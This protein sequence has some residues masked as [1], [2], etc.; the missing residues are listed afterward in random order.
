[1][2]IIR[3]GEL[4][5][6]R[7]LPDPA[8]PD[9]PSGISPEEAGT[10]PVS[11]QRATLKPPDQVEERQFALAAHHEIDLRNVGEEGTAEISRAVRSP[12]DDTAVGMEGA[13]LP[14]QV[15]GGG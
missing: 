8:P 10:L 1:M 3:N 15:K 13:D 12:Y 11:F 4:A 5:E 9:L 2:V 14:D 7:D 6:I